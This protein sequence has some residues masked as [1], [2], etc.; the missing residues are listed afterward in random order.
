MLVLATRPAGAR[1]V[2]AQSAGVHHEEIGAYLLGL[3]GLPYAVVEA[4]AHHHTPSRVPHPHFDIVAAVHVANILA[5]EQTGDVVDGHPR[6]S[7]DMP[8]LETLGVGGFLSG[9]RTIAADR[10]RNASAA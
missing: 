10:A 4:V 6:Q 5:H 2:V 1:A 9:W 8:Y 7:L 3:W